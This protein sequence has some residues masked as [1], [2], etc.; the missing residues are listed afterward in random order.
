MPWAMTRWPRLL[1]PLRRTP[2]SRRPRPAGRTWNRPG[3][4]RTCSSRWLRAMTSLRPPGRRTSASPKRSTSEPRRRAGMRPG[5]A[6][7]APAATHPAPEATG[8]GPQRGRSRWPRRRGMALYGYLLLLPA[9]IMLGVFTVYPLAK[10][11]IFSFQDYTRKNVFNP[12]A[13]ADFVG[14]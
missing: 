7:A 9:V 3:S 10:M 2:G 6:L 1:P 11:F 4:W 14:L 13:P 8:A 12:E 5:P